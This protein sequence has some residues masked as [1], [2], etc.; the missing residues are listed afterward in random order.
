MIN[1]NDVNKKNNLLG[2]NKFLGKILRFPL[3]LI[4]KD[5]SLPVLQGPGRGLKWI[6]GSYSHGCWLGSYEYEKQ[7]LLKE[8][9]VQSGDVVYDIGAH[10]GYFTIIFSKLVGSHGQVYAF[11][12][13]DENIDFIN[14]H[15][16]INSLAN[17]TPVK[18]G[19]GPKTEMAYFS[20]GAFTATGFRVSEGDMQF[21]VYNMEEYIN[22]NNIRLP[23]LIK[24]DIEGEEINV[25]PSILN[26]AYD[27]KVKLLISTHSNEITA[28]IASMLK[29]KGYKVSPHQWSNIP[30]KP[31][32]ENATL[33]LAVP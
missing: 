28:S 32:L 33:L 26:F 3:M 5:L 24:M 11:E 27:H 23:N 17:V 9:L 29:D 8:G 22:K 18:V 20:D 4:P 2:P 1:F 30:N 16:A 6:V 13:F 25:I 12:P 21:Q 14:K 31:K 15:I 10:V 19:I 7:E